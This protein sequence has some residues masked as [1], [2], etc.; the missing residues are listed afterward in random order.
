MASKGIVTLQL[1]AL[2][3]LRGCLSPPIVHSCLDAFF[4]LNVKCTGQTTSLFVISSCVWHSNQQFQK[5]FL[6]Y[7]LLHFFGDLTCY[8]EGSGILKIQEIILFVSRVISQRIN[9]P[10]RQRLHTE[11]IAKF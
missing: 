11:E 1:F 9:I 6:V 4:C 2:F 8:P 7:S 5:L 10:N 3:L